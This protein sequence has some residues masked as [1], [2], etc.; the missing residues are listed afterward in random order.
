[1]GGQQQAYF[2]EDAKFSSLHTINCIGCDEGE[3]MRTQL[4]TPQWYKF[5]LAHSAEP[6]N[7]PESDIFMPIK[8]SLRQF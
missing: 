1:M 2:D 5:R 4:F 6:A 7:Y 3:I 8:G